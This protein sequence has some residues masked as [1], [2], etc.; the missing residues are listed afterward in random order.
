[1]IK[2]G[3]AALLLFAAASCNDV[4]DTQPF[5]K[6]GEELVWSNRTNADAYMFSTY[7]D[8]VGSGNHY[9][10]FVNLEE[11]TPN[12]IHVNGSGNT[13]ESFDRS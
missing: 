6:F 7:N 11:W 3:C 9:V 13:R 1:M 10:D 5:D 8:I 2:T 4:L 12:S